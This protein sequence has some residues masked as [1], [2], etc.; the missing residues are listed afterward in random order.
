VED[1]EGGEVNWESWSITGVSN[2]Q[3]L[4]CWS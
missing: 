4:V 1:R 3:L 2:G